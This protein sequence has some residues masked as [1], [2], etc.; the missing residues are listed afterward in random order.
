VLFTCRPPM[1]HAAPWFQIDA[2]DA[3]LESI[4]LASA[5]ALCAATY[6]AG[7]LVNIMPSERPCA[8]QNKNLRCA[9]RRHV[10]STGCTHVDAIILRHLPAWQGQ[11]EAWTV[12]QIC[13][14]GKRP[15]TTTP[16]RK[17]PDPMVRP[18]FHIKMPPHWPS[19]P[20]P[21]GDQQ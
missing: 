13:R 21:Q 6:K 7:A 1:R 15:T 16:K 19:R 18:Q 10:R 12:K 8:P 2:C 5:L 4:T 20:E 14:A 11:T 17:K 9:A 3:V